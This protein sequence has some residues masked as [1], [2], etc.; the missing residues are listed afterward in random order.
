M[1]RSGAKYRV[2]VSGTR[3]ELTADEARRMWDEWPEEQ[4]S[5]KREAAF[6]LW[7]L[8]HLGCRCSPMLCR[9]I[10]AWVRR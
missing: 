3:V 9:P 5:G 10:T 8:D 4:R 1:G 6:I 2:A 7:D